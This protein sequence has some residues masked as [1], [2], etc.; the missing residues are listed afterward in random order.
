LDIGNGI[1]K[2]IKEQ[3]HKTWSN[4]TKTCL[5]KKHNNDTDI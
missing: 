4:T 1:K 5:V 3:G 2:S